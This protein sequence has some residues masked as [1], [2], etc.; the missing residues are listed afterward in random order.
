MD[1]VFCTIFTPTY[2]RKELLKRV[3]ESLIIQ[4]NNEFEWLIVDDGSSDGTEEYINS[5]I[6]EHN[7][8]VIIYKKKENGGKH[9]AI[10]YGLGFANGEVFAIVDSDDY[11]TAN[12]V[13]KIKEWFKTIIGDEKKF[14]GVAG[15]KG[16]SIVEAIGTTFDG[17]Y[18]DAKNNERS[19][20][21]IS[22]DKFE[23]YYTEILKKNK[24][25]EF[26]NEKFLTEVI[27]WNRIANQN[28]YIRWFNDIIYICEYLP[29]GLTDNRERLIE[30]SPAG[31]ALNIKEQVKFGNISLKQKLG[32]YSFYYSIRKKYK[33]IFEVAR[34]I[35]AN[36]IIIL[37]AYM[38]RVLFIDGGKT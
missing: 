22:G 33:N 3:Y 15:Q 9:R 2:N 34:E 36:P 32:Y 25:P 38:I 13:E 11:L 30:S 28:Y 37:V 12:A 5:I 31:Y 19:S 8:F 14:A 20:K 17:L 21:K 16:Y 29:Q 26:E 18:V 7:K 24:F 35:D 27:V 4:T 10:N 1:K 23:V 6:N